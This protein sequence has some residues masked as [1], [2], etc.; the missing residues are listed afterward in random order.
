LAGL[1]EGDVKV[2]G[3]IQLVGPGGDCAEE[4]VVNSVDNIDPGT[5]MVLTEEGSIE[6]SHYAYDKKVS[7]V[8]SG[9][10]NYKAG[11]L[12]GKQQS[13]SARVP[14]GL[15]GKAYCKVDA[16]YCSVRIGDLLTTSDTPGHAMMAADQFRAFGAVIGKALSSLKTGKGLIPILIA[17]Q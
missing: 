11:I 14:I 1:F 5:V 17:L 12:L 7:G 16:N 3:D 6:P 13:E 15:M 8:I 4:F 2:T 9:A 10:G